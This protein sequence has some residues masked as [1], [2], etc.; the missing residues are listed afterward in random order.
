MPRY[1]FTKA[2]RAE[3]AQ[4]IPDMTVEFDGIYRDGVLEGQTKVWVTCAA[5][6]YDRA[7]QAVAQFD[8]TALDAKDAQDRADDDAN[9]A[10]VR[11][12]LVALKAGTLSAANTQKVLAALIMRLQRQGV[13]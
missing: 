8:A 2:V 13:L 12:A 11:N 9:R 5:E 3:L 1:E 6:D 10:Q 7:A 4:A